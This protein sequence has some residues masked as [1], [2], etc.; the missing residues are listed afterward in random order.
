MPPP[1]GRFVGPSATVLA[2]QVAISPDGRPLTFI[3]AIGRGRQ[4]LWV[5]KLDELDANAV[6]G[7][8]GAQYP[9][10]SPDS[11][12]VGF[13]AQGKLKT[14]DI[15]GG[16]PTVLSDAPFDARGGSWSSDGTII[17]VPGPNAIIHRIAATGGVAT[18]LTALDAGRKEE[19]HRFPSFLPDGRHFLYVVRSERAEHRG[20]YIA[21]LD[22][23]QG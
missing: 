5:R 4:A 14:I 9:F 22:A 10:W 23:P 18:T 19:S 15:G 12:S 3:A 16:P 2:P 6:P 8:D 21:S 11:R 7:T 17:F 13:F 1:G 20:V